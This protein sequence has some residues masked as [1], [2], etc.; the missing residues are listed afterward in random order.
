MDYFYG[1][2][3]STHTATFPSFGEGDTIGCGI[4]LATRQVFFTLNGVLVSYAG[5][6]HVGKDRLFPTIHINSKEP[7]S[8]VVN[9]GSA[10]FAY[11]LRR[12]CTTPQLNGNPSLYTMACVTEIAMYCLTAHACSLQNAFQPNSRLFWVKCCEVV[13]R[14]VNKLTSCVAENNTELGGGINRWA[15]HGGIFAVAEASLLRHIAMVRTIVQTTKAQPLPNPVSTMLLDTVRLL[16]TSPMSTAQLAAA[17]LI[18]ELVSHVDAGLDP[19]LVT[20]V[21]RT[22]FHYARV[23]AAKTEDIPFAPRWWK[24]DPRV[25]VIAHAQ[26]ACVRPEKQRSIVLGNVL[27]PTGT[28]SFTVRVCRKGH[29]LGSSLKGGYYVGIAVASLALPISAVPGRRWK[30]AKPPVVWALHDTL[31]QL[32][33]AANPQ[34]MGNEFNRVFGNG[35]L[36]RV[37]VHRGIQA[38]DFYRED[39]HLS[40]LFV[41]IPSDIDL[42]PFVQLYNDDA[43]AFIGPGETKAPIGSSDLLKESSLDALR[44]M[45]AQKPFETRVSEALC[46]ELDESTDPS[47]SLAV[48]GGTPYLRAFKVTGHDGEPSQVR[49]CRLLRQNVRVSAGGASHWVHLSSLYEHDLPS[50]GA[51]LGEGRCNQSVGVLQQCVKALVGVLRRLALPLVT[52]QALTLT[53]ERHRR[54][55]VGIEREELDNLLQPIRVWQFCRIQQLTRSITFLEPPQTPKGY[56]FSSALSHP[57]FHF[58][59]RFCGRLATVPGDEEGLLVPFI[60]VAEPSVP[61][62]GKFQLRFQLVRGHIGQILGGGYYVG[63]CTALLGWRWHGLSSGSPQAWVLH[64]MDDA[65]W[66]LPHLCS[67]TQFQTVAEPKCIIVS[68]DIIRLEIDRCQGTMYAFRKGMNAEEVPLGL[69]YDN[70]PSGVELFPFIQ[71]YNAD[72]VAVLLPAGTDETAVRTAVQRPHLFASLSPLEKRCDV[73]STVGLHATDDDPRL[74]RCNKCIDYQLCRHCFELCMHPRHSFTEFGSRPL[75]HSPSPPGKLTVGM[76]V[77]VAATSALYIK[78]EGCHVDQRSLQ[79]VAVSEKRNSLAVWGIVHKGKAVFTAMVKAPDGQTLTSSTPTFIGVGRASDVLVHSAA[80]LRSLLASKPLGMVALCND[81]SLNPILRRPGRS[82]RGFRSGSTVSIEVDF[83]RGEVLIQCD[84]LS[85]GVQSTEIL[86]GDGATSPDLVGFV[87]FGQE[88]VTASICPEAT[89]TVHGVVSDVVDGFV[90]VLFGDGRWR[91]LRREHCCLPLMPPT[92]APKVGQ[93]GYT[94][95][96]EKLFQCKVKAAEGNEVSVLFLTSDV[97]CEV[98]PLSNFHT[99][100]YG[101]ITEEFSD[102]STFPSCGPTVTEG[103]VISRILLVLSTMC[104]NSQ[105]S[106]YVISHYSEIVDVLSCLASVRISSDI[107]RSFFSDVE[108]AV[109]TTHRCSK[110]LELM[111]E[112]LSG[113]VPQPPDLDQTYALRCNMLLCVLNGP[114]RGRILRVVKLISASAFEGVDIQI[115]HSAVLMNTAACIPVKQCDGKPWWTVGNGL[116]CT[117]YE[118]GLRMTCANVATGNMT[119]KGVWEGEINVRGEPPGSI[120][121]NLG[122]GYIG[123][124]CAYFCGVYAKYFVIGGFE[125]SSRSFSLIL[126]SAASSVTYRAVCSLTS[127]SNHRTFE[128]LVE[129]VELIL[130]GESQSGVAVLMEG[131][132]DADGSRVVG[133]WKPKLEKAGV[134][135]ISCT[136]HLALSLP[137][138]GAFYVEPLPSLEELTDVVPR[139]MQSRRESIKSALRRLVVLL[140]RHLCLFFLDVGNTQMANLTHVVICHHAHPVTER[141][142][143]ACGD[144][145]QLQLLLH[146]VSSEIACSSTRPQV[147]VAL[148]SLLT[149]C[150]LLRSEVISSFPSVFWDSFHAIVT[151]THR[152]TGKQRYYLLKCITRLVEHC[153][154]GGVATCAQLL[155]VLLGWVDQYISNHPYPS[156]IPEDVAAGV[157]LAICLPQSVTADIVRHIPVASLRCL[158][159]TARALREK[160]PLPKAVDMEEDAAVR[161]APSVQAVCEFGELS[162]GLLLVGKVMSCPMAAAH[163]KY[164]YEVALPDGLPA[165]FAV[166]W[167]TEQH[168]D[169]PAQHVGSDVHSFAF[170]G[171]GLSFSG[172]E[173]E[174]KPGREPLPGCVIGCLL[175]MDKDLVAWSVDGVCG[176]FVSIPIDRGGKTLIAFVS[177]GPSN[178]VR[179]RLNASEFEDS[180]V[181]YSDLSGC[182]THVRINDHDTTTCRRSSLSPTSVSFYE[183]LASY[184]SEVEDNKLSNFAG[185][186]L[187]RYYLP[188]IQA[189]GV[190]EVLLLRKY[191]LLIGLTEKDVRQHTNVIRV[192]ESCMKTARPYLNLGGEVVESHLS[193]AFLFLK[194]AA[195]RSLMRRHLAGIPSARTNPKPHY[196]TVRITELYGGDART[197]EVALQR[198]V[199][200]QIYKQIGCFSPEQFVQ[201]PLFKVHLRITHSRHTPQDLGGPY[202]Q[203]W[204]FLSEEMMTP[205]E[206][207]Y[208]NTAFHRNPL[209]CFGECLQRVGLIPNRLMTSRY[210]L[211]LFNFLGKLMGHSAVAKI[212]FALDM[213]PFLWKYLV[214]DTLTVRDYYRY[215]DGTMENC[216]A[217]EA[218]LLS[219]EV[220]EAIPTFAENSSTVGCVDMDVESKLLCRRKIAENCLIHSLDVQLNVIREGL[221]SVLPRHIVRCLSWRALE[222][223]VCGEP[224]LTPEVMRRWVDVRLEPPRDKMFWRAIDEFS[225]PQRALFMCFGCGQKRP[226]LAEKIKV[227]QSFES[228]DYLPRAQTCSSSVTIPP[229]DTYELL[230][231]KLTVAIAHS[232]EMEL[233]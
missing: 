54:R 177:T 224:D 140:S 22:L 7:V 127:E 120:S 10:A 139:A 3:G 149:K 145:T 228:T 33:H 204:T 160:F 173:K 156:E 72:A 151:A 229:Y 88:N 105:L 168:R 104:S 207:C 44:S 194:C 89:D 41:D 1:S 161:S 225:V 184:L 150:V 144:M 30:T 205:A 220:E 208:P 26:L 45:A 167:G 63:L 171:S 17:R 121:M 178:G 198:S 73:C 163:G 68:G 40:T 12:L 227:V 119:V 158:V 162:D 61:L 42:V 193:D 201:Q 146:K 111:N 232:M 39:V 136:D 59:A 32:S 129:Q 76:N 75:I 114:C 9:F 109:A 137:V 169:I 181:E 179:I 86:R 96:G 91:V 138:V 112:R 64:D 20:Q 106:P 164:Y 8:F 85:L 123:E 14:G 82:A 132:V 83:L 130:S 143:A 215:V 197:Y 51:V 233:A 148:A 210:N 122:A 195:R 185:N 4:I 80:S 116:P 97:G 57:G 141:L 101:A 172:R 211:E 35:E 217:S 5:C 92:E 98:I 50:E 155:S 53:E 36:I 23:P 93:L 218:F 62:R 90:Q 199:L 124:A 94:F 188:S 230:R 81:S 213:S 15:E 214:G 103:F 221:W 29:T 78:S 190:P 70:I 95:S 6:V 189:P 43:F 226:P 2:S 133:S 52:T 135:A 134:F 202:R 192:I 77:V 183:Q 74:Y 65:P 37:V 152:C 231:D 79:F 100:R 13:C 27:P 212:P 154:G 131:T 200:S 153:G 142:L 222:H 182:Y 203:L 47:V 21:T 108:E 147:C 24:C 117:Q 159:E 58:P 223:T 16:L 102:H 115:P 157:E 180:P 84:W 60:A 118:Y 71:L 166:G 170:T 38:V 175:N 28:T 219:T 67:C 25:A 46:G 165:Q 49:V 176:P 66:R 113:F 110:T 69:L 55:V 206:G 216:V 11:D 209:F 128:E 107:Y 187:I 87:L 48:L 196:I 191:P 126:F 34:V 125:R 99:D 31:P 186:E 56:C 19:D 174:Y 18:P